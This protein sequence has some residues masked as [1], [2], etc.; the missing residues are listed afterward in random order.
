MMLIL[1]FLLLFL[2]ICSAFFSGSETAVMT[3]NRYRLRHLA[4]KGNKK[5]KKI[6]TL[7][8]RTDR[9]LGTILLGNTFTNILASSLAT[10]L[11]VHYMGPLGA[12]VGTIILTIL[13]LVF[14]E[15]LPKTFASLKAESF[16]FKVVGLLSVLVYI[17]RPLVYLMTLIT[18]LFI[19][20]LGIDPHKTKKDVLSAEELRT[21]VEGPLL[22]LSA[23]NREM[24]LGVLDLPHIAVT[25]I[26]VQKHDV[27]GVDL[28]A[29]VL[30]ILRLLSSSQ[31]TRLPVY[32]DDVNNILGIIHVRH[33]VNTF[34]RDD[35]EKD[36]LIEQIISQLS[37]PY[38]VPESTTLMNQLFKFQ[39]LN[40]RIALVVDEYGDIQ[41]LVTLEDILEEIVGDFTAEITPKM[42]EITP[43]ADGWYL[44][45]G[46]TNVR[47]LNRL[48]GWK[49]PMDGAK[50][51]SGM[52]VEYI[53][54]IPPPG[55]GMRIAGYPIEVLQIKGHAIK[56]V[57][58]K[59]E[60]KLNT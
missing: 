7:L 31:H 47:V 13:V 51:L 8:Q 46:G 54:M 18:N 28:N 17:L 10:V 37:E 40:E 19:K 50:T 36:N 45:D 6:H 27:L 14:A 59:P 20:S 42:Q 3:A 1:L 24:L 22:T 25:D 30:D 16:S 56:T 57:R 48:M 44:I 38:Y 2:I 29:S 52:I 55:T 11:A 12:L 58:L 26:M 60:L 32:R 23:R 4:D 5:A 21:V 49:L 39:L 9:L 15:L 33:L 35:F 43:Q 34:A 41:G 53:E